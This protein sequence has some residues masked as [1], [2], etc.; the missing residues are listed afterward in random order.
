MNS[1]FASLIVLHDAALSADADKIGAV[2][3]VVSRN[4]DAADGAVFRNHVAHDVE[5][6]YLEGL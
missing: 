3:H 5:D 6:F 1:P 2:K 4:A